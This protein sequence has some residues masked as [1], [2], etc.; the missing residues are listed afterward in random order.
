MAWLNCWLLE[1]QDPEVAACRITGRAARREKVSR[2]APL[3]RFGPS[4]SCC[5]GTS[6]G[7]RRGLLAMAGRTACTTRASAAS[8]STW[9]WARAGT[10]TTR[11]CSGEGRWSQSWRGGTAA[12]AVATFVTC[13]M[14]RC[15]ASRLVGGS[16]RVRRNDPHS[17]RQVWTLLVL[18]AHTTTRWESK[19]HKEKSGM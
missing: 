5:L 9:P 17:P 2:H 13:R 3:R 4:T 7:R 19:A 14:A 18:C 11:T 10:S 16:N 1:Q 6:T 12:S 8:P 15:G